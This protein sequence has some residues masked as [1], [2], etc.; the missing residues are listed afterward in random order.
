MMLS[1]SILS[2]QEPKKENIEKL[3]QCP[4]SYLHL[5][6]MD[7]IFVS[8][9]TS[10]IDE[11]KSLLVENRIPLDIHFMVSDVST[12]I[13]SFAILNPTYITFHYEIEDDIMPLIEQVK[14]KGSGVGL[15]ISPDTNVE[16]LKPYLP[17]L[18]LVLVMSVT[19]GRGG[20]AFLPSSIEKINTLKEWRD[21]NHYHYMI[22]VDG[23]INPETKQLCSNADMIV[24]GSYI[25]KEEDFEKQIMKLYV[26]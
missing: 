15:A 24:V 19:P 14:E 12:F 3:N 4:I 16:A 20:Q 17:Y 8:N 26:K 25:T 10:N 18:D 6:V 9:K 22:E 13:D 21:S 1:V 11:I 5:D 7:G 2:L 23:G